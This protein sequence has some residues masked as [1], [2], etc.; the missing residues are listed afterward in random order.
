MAFSQNLDKL[1]RGPYKLEII[2]GRIYTPALKL[3]QNNLKS[4]WFETGCPRGEAH[5][6][7]SVQFQRIREGLGRN[8]NAV[9]LKSISS[10]VQV[11]LMFRCKS[12]SE[13]L[14][15][16]TMHQSL[17]SAFIIKFWWDFTGCSESLA[18]ERRVL[19]VL[20]N[21]RRVFTGCSESLGSTGLATTILMQSWP[22]ALRIDA[23]YQEKDK[24]SKQDEVF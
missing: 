24:E 20:T 6:E 23:T 16:N 19:R 9:L 8:S 7:D 3:C 10:N 14:N 21:E 13:R 5:S 12:K 17:S 1:V 2:F 4:C 18:N 11:R 22:A 15:C